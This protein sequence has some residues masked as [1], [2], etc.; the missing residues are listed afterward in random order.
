MTDGAWLKDMVIAGAELSN[1]HYE[2]LIARY[3]IDAGV[4]DPPS[5]LD[6]VC[7]DIVGRLLVYAASGFACILERAIAEAD[8]APP[9]VNL[10]VPTVL[11]TLKIPIRYVDPQNG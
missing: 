6:E 3:D 5:G 11:A 2:T 1:Q 9:A 8:V 7:R 10:T 4:V